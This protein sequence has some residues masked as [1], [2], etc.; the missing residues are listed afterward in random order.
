[1]KYAAQKLKVGEEYLFW[2]KVDLNFFGAEM[3][4]PEIESPQ[5][6]NI[7]RPIYPQTAGINSKA[8]EK[9][10]RTALTALKD[11]LAHD[12][13]P[14]DLV[15][16]QKLMPYGQAISSI[17][18]PK[19]FEVLE[20]ARKRLIF[21]ELL[22]LQLGLLVMRGR[23]ESSTGA[24]ISRDFTD[25]F[26]KLLPFEMTGAQKRC[27]KEGV[28][29]MAR[30]HPMSRLLQG[31][32]G[33]GKTAVAAA[34]VYNCI[35]NS[36]QAAL[37]APTEIL[38]GQHHKTFSKFLA[39]KGVNIALLTGS[40]SAAEKRRIK[41]GLSSGEINLVVGTHALIQEDVLFDKLGL[42]ITDEQ[43]RFG[44]GQR[45]KLGAKGL[46][47]HVY[48]MSATPIPRTMALFIYGDLDISVLDELPPGRQKVATYAVDTALRAR[49]LNYVK[50]HLDKGLQ[51]YIIC[52]LVEEG[53]SELVAATRYA[54]DLSEGFFADYKVG[55]LHGK[56]KAKDKD[57]VMASFASGE[58]DLL[59]STTVV[60]V[61]VDVPN[62]AIMVIENAERFGLSQ[63]HQ[64]RGRIGRGEHESTCILISDA[65]NEE[66]KRRLDI[67][68][69]TNNGFL[70][71]E[72]DLKNRGP[73]DFFG[74]RQHGL[75]ELKIADMLNDID[76]LR[77]TQ[78]LAK[79]IVSADP[80]LSQT[81]NRGLKAA[82]NELFDESGIHS[83]N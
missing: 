45:A 70:I 28:K 62:A 12:P 42:V 13:L 1:N 48:V 57:A 23:E 31:D 40:T 63:L 49:A 7:I 25:E 9:L 73:G 58:T 14:C 44:V 65:Q 38:A 27:V 68:A 71:A 39:D 6:N 8:L 30:P 5:G 82:V 51:G 60:E 54:S 80:T 81:Q 69:K 34:L 46:N 2:G 52:P 4:S 11:D 59:V 15:E 53:E 16:S 20:E 64:L 56:M 77:L 33:S 50:K 37:M 79:E 35:K 29:D 72:E 55:L 76:M 67:M 10:V 18:F 41:S 66:A 22:F 36:F 75:P 83:F 32:V 19:N 61:G 24:V 17:H 26:A 43:H 78:T 47:P 21:E 74:S 3:T